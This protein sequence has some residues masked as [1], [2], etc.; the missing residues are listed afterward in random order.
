MK[1]KKKKQK[2]KKKMKKKKKTWD[3]EVC[4]KKFV[5]KLFKYFLYAYT[6]LIF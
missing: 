1:K 5:S 4:F 3:L 2:K 6:I